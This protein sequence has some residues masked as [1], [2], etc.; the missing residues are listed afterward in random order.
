MKYSRYNSIIQN[1]KG[2]QFLVNCLHDIVI[3]LDPILCEII[4]VNEANDLK[5][6]HT[7]LFHYLK[8]KKMIIPKSFNEIGISIEKRQQKLMGN[9]ILRITINPTLDCNLKCWYCY[10]KKI[11]KS[12]MTI[13]TLKNVIDFIRKKVENNTFDIIYLSFFG[14]EPM[15]GYD[16]VIVPLLKA[17]KTICEKE[18]IQ[19]Y[20]HYTTNATLLTKKRIETLLGYSENIGIQVAF[21]GGRDMHNKIKFYANKKGCYSSMLLNVKEAIRKGISTN[22]RCNVTLENASTFENLITDLKDVSEYKNFRLSF[23]KVWQEKKSSQ[24]TMKI[25]DLQPLLDKISIKSNL[26]NIEVRQEPCYADYENSFVIN[27]NGDVY[28]CTARNFTHKNRIGF[29][30]KGGHLFYNEEFMK[31]V[32][33]QYKPVCAICKILPIC[34]ICSQSKYETLENVCPNKNDKSAEIYIIKNYY[35][36]ELH[37]H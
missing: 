29:L 32:N 2:E 3:Q 13:E 1:D 6:I 12:I 10:E 36:N 22:I 20:H 35:Y 9:K 5:T 14:G 27:F 19:L 18:N 25:K 4:K 11:S 24:L 34:P 7:D 33:R 31:R 23:Q 17:T 21:D 15:M 37:T 28:K 30:T 26:H 16:K 8:K